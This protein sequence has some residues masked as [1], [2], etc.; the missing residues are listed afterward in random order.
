[1]TSQVSMNGGDFVG[2]LAYK[3]CSK[4][5]LVNHIEKLEKE[6]RL[7]VSSEEKLAS[8]VEDAISNELDTLNEAGSTDFSSIEELYDAW[9]KSNE[10]IKKQD[11][12]ILGLE[13]KQEQWEGMKF[14]TED[15]IRQCY[16]DFFTDHLQYDD[17]DTDDEDSVP[18]ASKKD[19]WSDIV[20]FLEDTCD[21]EF[22]CDPSRVGGKYLV[23]D[24]Q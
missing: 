16:V 5:D 12:H 17:Y 1:M 19:P 2:Q 14:Y 3:T 6:L 11:E 21:W 15:E 4:Q 20:E 9:H 24:N 7:G 22:V 13:M 18:K 10:M 8:C 23:I